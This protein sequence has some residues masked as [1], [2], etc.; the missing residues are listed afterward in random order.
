M[1][2]TLPLDTIE[3]GGA[4]HD[5][6]YNL[7]VGRS[8]LKRTV[9]NDIVTVEG[10]LELSLPDLYSIVQTGGG[11][12]YEYLISVKSDIS[13]LG[14]FV[15]E[16]L[17]NRLTLNESAQSEVRAFKNWF[18]NTSTL[19]KKNDDSEVLFLSNP[20]GTSPSEYLTGSQ[21]FLLTALT[22]HS[23]SVYTISQFNDMIESGDWSLVELN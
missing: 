2:F 6:Y 13:L 23:V 8:D 12:V 10:D 18:E 22:T 1:R 9:S 4:L 15:S 3:V 20:V 14:E 21:I 19:Y 5:Y 16:G 11:E 17:P 7:L